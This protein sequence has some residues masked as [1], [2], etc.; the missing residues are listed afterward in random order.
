MGNEWKE[1]KLGEIV[2]I[3]GDGLHGTPKYDKNGEYYFINGNNLNGKIVINS[4]TKR[5]NYIEFLKYKK[6]LNER[7]I[8]VSINGT[9]GNVAFYNG[10]KIILGK[11]ACYFNISENTDKHFIKY[12]LVSNIFKDYIQ[13]YATGTTIKNM[14]LK[15][16]REFSFNLP[17]LPTQKKIAEILSSID[18]KIELNNQMNKTLEEMAQAIFKQWFMDFEFP[19]ENGE[20]YKSSGGEMVESELGLIPKGWSVKELGE[21]FSF[22]KGKKP[23]DIFEKKD[24]NMKN[25]LTI[26]VLNSNGNLFANPEKVILVNKFN[27]L[28]VMDGASSGTIFYGKDGIVASTLSKLE[29]IDNE[30]SDDFLYF[31]IK[32]Y[33]NDIKQHTT[34]S[35]IPHTDKEYVYRIKIAFTNSIILESIYNKLENV[36]SKIIENKEETETLTQIR[37]TI[38]PKLMN[39]EIDVNEVKI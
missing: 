29:V 4:Q 26:D 28:M 5:V 1:V 19:N 20:P 9:L 18:D 37:D 39:G 32:Y 23:K 27:N 11:S 2:D 25:Y 14:G 6:N 3:L 12:I 24:E 15:Q 31:I 10:E 22:V 7:T 35:A 16:M 30:I 13:N 8:L 38:L 17:H 36:R 33:E 34:G 21:V